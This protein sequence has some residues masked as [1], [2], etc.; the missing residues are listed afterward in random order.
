MGFSDFKISTHDRGKV[1]GS[2]VFKLFF[3]PSCKISSETYRITF[4][5]YEPVFSSPYFFPR[6]GQVSEFFEILS[7]YH[8]WSD[9]LWR[10][11]IEIIHDI[12]KYEN[13]KER[14]WGCFPGAWYLE[15]WG[16]FSKIYW[17]PSRNI[18]LENYVT[19]FWCH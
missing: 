12:W 15:L 16:H 14:G 10:P 5:Y 11:L 3:D 13:F 1:G 18:S 19:T 2:K 9:F 4:S 6:R 8:F 7:F 17:H